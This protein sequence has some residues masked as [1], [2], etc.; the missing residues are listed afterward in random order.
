MG[1]QST[2]TLEKVIC[3]TSI[4]VGAAVGAGIANEIT[5][6]FFENHIIKNTYIEVLINSY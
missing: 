6:Q 3:E 1:P 2:V 5:K 4:E